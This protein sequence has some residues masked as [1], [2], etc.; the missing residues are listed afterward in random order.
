MFQKKEESTCKDLFLNDNFLNKVLDDLK[1]RLA[2]RKELVAPLENAA[3]TYGTSTTYLE[4]ILEYWRT[5]YNW[6]KRQTL[7]NKYPQYITNIQGNKYFCH[8]FKRA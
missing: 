3:W 5:D 8:L 1:D 4:N 7:L 6:S 2:K